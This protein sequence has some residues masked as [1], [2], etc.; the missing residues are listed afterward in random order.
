MSWVS[1]RGYF[2]TALGT[3]EPCDELCLTC[4]GTSTQCLSCREGLHLANGQC[5]QNCSPMSYVAEDGT[6]RR[7]A[8]HCDVCIDFS[9]CTSEWSLQ[10]RSFKRLVTDTS[11]RALKT[12]QWHFIEIILNSS[13]LLYYLVYYLLMWN[14]VYRSVRTYLGCFWISV[15]IRL[16]WIC[17]LLTLCNY[18]ISGCS[19]LYL[20]LNGACKAVCPKGYFEDLDQGICVS[21]HPTCATCSGPLSDD[22]E[23]CSALNPKL[24]E[25][26]CLE[27]C[28]AGT[29][30]QTSDKECQGEVLTVVIPLT[31]KTSIILGSV[32][33]TLS[34]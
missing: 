29:Y 25:G 24:Y 17:N 10:L 3:C 33:S 20:L 32:N 9:T 26:M 23:T 4:D 14:Y 31:H 18:L 16:H 21:C 2:E 28:P 22:C 30:Y 27:E 19:F 11:K 13:S 5:R 6:C 12:H 15:E 7:C 1:C 34:S 8:P